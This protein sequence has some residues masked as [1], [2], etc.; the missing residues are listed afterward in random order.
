MSRPFRWQISR[1][2]QLGSLADAEPHFARPDSGFITSL[3]KASA[4]ILAMSDGADIAFI[5][6]TPENF[7]DYL[8]GVFEG[9]AGAPT[10]HLVQFSLR[11]PGLDGVKAIPEAQLAGIFDYFEA[12]GVSAA[13]IAAGERP[14]ARV[15][16]VARGGTMESVVSL[17]HLQAERT[18]T[19]WK[20]VQRRLTIIGLRQCT[21]NSPN[22]WRW[23]QHAQWLGL[24]PDARILNV[25]AEMGFLIMLANYQPKTTQSHSP[26]RWAAPERGA[27]PTVPDET[28]EAMAFAVQVFD[29]GN[30]REERF[31]L[32]GEIARQQQMRQP[33]T[34]A[35]V[36][37]LKG[38]G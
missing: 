35:L 12:E 34:R 28:R 6:R 21:K 33:A 3:R 37:R 17:L 14:L 5:G 36:S 10:L 32:A 15:D 38:L 7:F 23:Q 30:A 18:G 1:R 19:D 31:A 29:A 2:E 26:E 22:T 20:S 9:V 16:F 25:S 8:S 27:P 13:Q 11:W 4:R 24:I